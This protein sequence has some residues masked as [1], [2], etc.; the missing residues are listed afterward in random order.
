M[1]IKGDDF[2]HISATFS[3]HV[4]D[5]DLAP[6]G[7]DLMIAYPKQD[8]TFDIR[9]L[10]REAG[11]G[12]K[13]P[14][15]PETASCAKNMVAVREPSVS[16][17]ASKA[18]VSM[19]VGCG[20]DAHWQIYEVEGLQQG[21]AVKF[22][23]LV[24]PEFNNLSPI[25]SPEGDG[26]EQIIYSSDMSWHG[27]TALH[28]KCI[29]E[30]EEH[31]GTCGLFKL[32]RVGNVTNLDPS[33]SGSFTPT[34]DSFGRVIFTRWDHLINDQQ[35]EDSKHRLEL[36]NWLSEDMNAPTERVANATTVVHSVFPERKFAAE[37]G[38]APHD[39]N[40][41]LAW[42]L[43][44]D[45]T[46]GE[47]LN[48]FGR[49]ELIFIPPARSG[50]TAQKL[51]LQENLSA[52]TLEIFRFLREDPTTP[53]RYFALVSPEFGTCGGGA[54]VTIDSAPDVLPNDVKISYVTDPDTA[55]AGTQPLF[56]TPLPAA[57]GELW[58]SV[59]VSHK[60]VSSK[61]QGCD[62]RLAR[63]VEQGDHFVA[64]NH[65]T[66]GAGLQRILDGELRTLWEWEAVEVR[67]RTKP[68]PAVESPLEAGE[69][70]AFEAVFGAGNGQQG[71][72]AFRTF[73]KQNK[74]ALAVVRNATWRQRDDLQQPFNLSVL[75]SEIVTKRTGSKAD[76]LD[77]DHLQIFTGQQLRGFDKESNEGGL[78][79][80]R[81]VLAQPAHEI[82]VE[83][84]FGQPRNVNVPAAMG[85]PAG[86]TKISTEDGSVAFIV[87]ANR[88]TAWQTIDSTKPGSPL[89]RTD[90]VVRERYWIGFQ[91]G[92]MR[93]CPACHGGLDRDQ[94]QNGK[95]FAEL[96]ALGNESGKATQAL[97]ELLQY[98]K[99]N[100]FNEQ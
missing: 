58:A 55:N 41:F 77:I 64:A 16:W 12:M 29:D 68:A 71:L 40:V 22:T 28:L 39:Q 34:I 60:I 50:E 26:T 31:Q 24:Q 38:F 57:N 20:N 70:Q 75:G 15:T 5:S 53:G 54:V 66:P 69:M 76:V 46:A 48:H 4:P 21:Q 18:L 98:Y 89:L 1:P 36:F 8:G 25:Y 19:V 14:N 80:Y 88:P 95:T 10:T 81:R 73:L 65:V 42:Q 72:N 84:N 13:D 9:N 92:E 62:Y 61:A 94:A 49:Q 17:D 30:Y 100:F 90:G 33:P 3:N 87:E 85:V 67:A 91:P 82:L 11:F 52:N 6:R 35:E 96:K 45:G 51:G 32:D 2:G 37:E 78:E 44:V 97:V 59:S 93:M 7:G 23:H 47:T 99:E 56:R 83:D 86:A 74:L 79:N 27:P 63:M 43:N